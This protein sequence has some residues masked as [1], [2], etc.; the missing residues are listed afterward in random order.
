MVLS[1][2]RDRKSDGARAGPH[3]V[4]PVA[5]SLFYFLLGVDMNAQNVNRHDREAL[6][7][8]V[9]DLLSAY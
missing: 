7:P 6:K 5:S 8:H 1:L 9:E 2:K 4:A 3:F